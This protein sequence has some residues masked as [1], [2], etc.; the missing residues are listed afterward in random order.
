MTIWNDAL[1]NHAGSSSI[2]INNN[3]IS[4]ANRY[5]VLM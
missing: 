5:M 4:A 2:K 3:S 1:R